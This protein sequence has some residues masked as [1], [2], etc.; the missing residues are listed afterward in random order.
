MA[1]DRTSTT[2]TSTTTSTSNSASSIQWQLV[3][4]PTGEP[5][6]ENIARVQ[7]ELPALTDGEVRV[8]NTYFSVDPYMRGRMNEGRS[9]VPPYALG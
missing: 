5:T 7:A 9:Y 4:R 8:R 1:P 2:T 3:S 6:S